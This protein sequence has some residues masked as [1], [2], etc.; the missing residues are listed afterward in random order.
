MSWFVSKLSLKSE[1]SGL[2][3]LISTSMQISFQNVL[4][5]LEIEKVDGRS[6]LYKI[7][8][9]RIE[10]ESQKEHKVHL[11]AV[12]EG[13]TPSRRRKLLQSLLILQEEVLVI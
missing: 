1:G 12:F 11:R 2:Q 13:Q 3:K 9:F 5:Q 10:F 7:Q 4:P 6:C 8:S